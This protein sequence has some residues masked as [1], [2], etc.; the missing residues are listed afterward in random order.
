MCW[1][2]YAYLFAFNALKL[3]VGRQEGY[4][5]CK[6]LVVGCWHG[7]LSGTRCRLAYGPGDATATH[8]LSVLPF[9]HSLTRVVPDK[10]PWNVCM[11]VCMCVCVGVWTDACFPCRLPCSMVTYGLLGSYLAQAVLGDYDP[12]EH[13]CGCNYLRHIQFAP[14]ASQTD[15]LLETV[16]ELH[17]SRCGLSPS[18]A[19]LEYLVNA[20]RLAMYG[21][22]LHPVLVISLLLPLASY[23]GI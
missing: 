21:V 19:E 17:R 15:E 2:T 1:G 3:L 4:P 12:A 22:D 14:A 23:D 16:V 18:S 5:A 13:G 20:S 8:C 10:G 6:N 11:C 7:Y 9:W